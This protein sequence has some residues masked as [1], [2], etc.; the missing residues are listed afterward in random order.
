M[1][2]DS[3]EPHMFPR[4]GICGGRVVPIPGVGR[5][6]LYAHGAKPVAIPHNALIPTCNW[7]GET[8][9]GPED[10]SLVDA[11]VARSLQIR[12][13]EAE[14][15]LEQALKAGLA[16]AERLRVSLA[17]SQY[18]YKQAVALWDQETARIEDIRRAGDVFEPAKPT[19]K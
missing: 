8:Y 6:R 18:N 17:A 15:L 7:C 19:K 9:M 14:A 4:C 13:E 16:E 2:N 3:S 11:S 12:A 10:S 1:T 5:T